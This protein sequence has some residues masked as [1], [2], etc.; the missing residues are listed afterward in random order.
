MV[1][2]ESIS[3]G[4]LQPFLVVT[5]TSV[6]QKRARGSMISFPTP[7]SFEASGERGLLGALRQ[8]TWLPLPSFHL[9]NIYRACVRHCVGLGHS[10]ACPPRAYGPGEAM[11]FSELMGRYLCSSGLPGAGCCSVSE[12][13]PRR[14]A[15]PSAGH[16]GRGASLWWRLPTVQ[17]Q[18]S[19]LL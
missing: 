12:Q 1:S 18:R 17:R 15:E 16:C 5:L 11:H 8:A 4:S 19:K 13:R 2:V 6:Q 3:C 10:G 9:M 7:G 14:G